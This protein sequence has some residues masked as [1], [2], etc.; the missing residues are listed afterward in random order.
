MTHHEASE[1]FKAVAKENETLKARVKKLEA[2][3]AEEKERNVTFKP[4]GPL[5]AND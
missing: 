4:Y 3:L 2:E 5:H 1:H